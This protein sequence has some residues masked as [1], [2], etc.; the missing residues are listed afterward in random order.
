[1]SSCRLKRVNMEKY[2][3][4]RT[5]YDQLMAKV[6]DPN[7]QKEHPP[8]WPMQRTDF[9]KALNTKWDANC[10]ASY[11]SDEW[12]NARMPK[13]ESEFM[14]ESNQFM[15]KENFCGCPSCGGYGC[16]CAVP[17]YGYGYIPVCQCDSCFSNMTTEGYCGRAYY[18]DPTMPIEGFKNTKE[19]YDGINNNQATYTNINMLQKNGCLNAEQPVN[20]LQDPYNWWS[21][22]AKYY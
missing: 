18:N 15:S 11:L 5:P 2:N 1:M 12:K 21:Y 3:P 9:D 4:P 19:N 20:S 6:Y 13:Y 17:K 22:S 14:P 16:S 7:A 10:Q 8:P